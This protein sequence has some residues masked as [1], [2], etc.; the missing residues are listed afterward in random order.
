M[1]ETWQDALY[2]RYGYKS[3]GIVIPKP[4]ERDKEHE[5]DDERLRKLLP[6]RYFGKSAFGW[7]DSASDASQRKRAGLV[8]VAISLA[9][10][11]FVGYMSFHC[12]KA[13]CNDCLEHLEK[14]SNKSGAG[15]V[16]KIV[17]EHLPRKLVLYLENMN[18]V[19]CHCSVCIYNFFWNAETHFE[20]CYYSLLVFNTFLAFLMA[21]VVW[22]LAFIRFKHL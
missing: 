20:K 11:G 21:R 4:P 19:E 8:L 15:H 9:V 5:C 12:Y 2:R 1:G 10:M 18:R 14:Y 16:T 7:S 3:Q 22:W 17:G 13:S 6:E